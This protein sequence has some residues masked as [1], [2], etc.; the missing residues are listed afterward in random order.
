MKASAARTPGQRITG[1]SFGNARRLAGLRCGPVMRWPPKLVWPLV[2]QANSSLPPSLLSLPAQKPENRDPRDPV[3]PRAQT[4]IRSVR[5][6]HEG[7]FRFQTQELLSAMP[8][9][10]RIP[11]AR[12]PSAH[13]SPPPHRKSPAAGATQ[14]TFGGPVH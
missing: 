9:R 13:G 12:E 4:R 8:P 14:G 2:G 3:E 7:C 5:D 10:C 11:L 1:P 6:C